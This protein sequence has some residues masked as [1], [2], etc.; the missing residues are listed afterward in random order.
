MP[1]IEWTE[2]ELQSWC[3]DADVA[4]PLTQQTASS[5]VR[6]ALLVSPLCGT[7]QA[8]LR[9]LEV[10]QT[11]QPQLPIGQVNVNVC[12]ELPYVW[13]VESVPCLV[14]L[15][16]GHSMPIRRRYKLEGITSLY[17]WLQ[18]AAGASIQS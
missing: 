18:S 14:E 4:K 5:P 3:G 1:I 6:Y 7:C 9:M 10:I 12:R 17:A 2:A 13:K 16:R 15:R 8:G 11:M